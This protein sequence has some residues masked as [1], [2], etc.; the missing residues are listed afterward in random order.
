MAYRVVW[1]Q[2][3]VDDLRQIVEFI[4]LDDAVAAANLADRVLNRIEQ[5][6][7][8]PFS[9]RAVPEKSEETIREVILRPY[10]IV[11]QMDDQRD[12]IHILRIWHAARG[13]PDLE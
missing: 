7:E 4:A 5:A 3:A 10:R 11:Y 8:L 6:A 2:T 12:A 9:N 13:V 1:S